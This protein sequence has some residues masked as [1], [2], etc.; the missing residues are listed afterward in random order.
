MK[1]FMK[2]RTGLV[3]WLLAAL[4]AATAAVP[5]LAGTGG[6]QPLLFLST[7][8]R[9]I[10]EAQKV[11]DVILRG[12]GRPVEFIPVEPV[13]F[14]DRVLAEHRAGRVSVGV[15]GGVHGDFPALA[16]A[17]ALDS[18]DDVLS[19]LQNRAFPASFVALGRLGG[20]HQLYIPWLQ[21]TYIMVANRQALAYLPRGASLNSLTYDQLRQWGQNLYEATGR[22]L[23]GFP[24]G[25]TGLMHRFFQG[26]L[27]PS[28]TGS[29]VTEFRSAQA[30][31]MWEAFR[32]TWA[33]VNPQSTSYAFMQEPLLA[34]EVWVAWDHTARLIEALRQRPDDFV[35]F[36]APIGP[37][38]RGFMPVLTGLAIPRGAP[39]R[40]GAAAL[41]E[42][43]TRPDVQA[44]VMQEI[45]G[46]FPVVKAP[47]ESSLP[48][49][50]R[51]AAEA[52]ATQAASPEAVPSLLPV[53]L[54]TL[55]GEFNRIYLDTFARIV[56][57]NQPV[58]PVLEQQAEALR[59][60][61]QQ[62]GAPCWPPDKP[63]NGAC[64]VR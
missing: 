61:M 1:P 30:E 51:M 19:A 22:R 63:S 3:V 45:G 32:Q 50:V 14:A 2:P 8:L 62:A 11:R 38:G 5:V 46:F 64:P 48:A 59:R 44:L 26:Y 13:P 31:A 53:G 49:G 47:L 23:L 17:G 16:A 34:G 55:D 56:L 6:G 52:V 43:L 36:P 54:G 41:V 57:R 25:P 28:Y 60:I 4:A 21:A 18:L 40:A 29:V 42:Y 7:Q 33:Y 37:V 15:L 58:R 9:P 35:A 10:E 12:F 39:D 27:Y 24:A 20:D